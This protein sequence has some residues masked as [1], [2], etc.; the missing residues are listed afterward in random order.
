MT[1]A[2]LGARSE[3]L[4]G[5]TRRR[6]LGSVSWSLCWLEGDL[7]FFSTGWCR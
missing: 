7:P 5:L 4:N 6:F 2:V 1:S 3:I